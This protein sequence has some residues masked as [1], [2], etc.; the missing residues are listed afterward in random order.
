MQ[1]H[2]V[3]EAVEQ[4]DPKATV[5]DKV[6]K[7][8]LAKIYQSVPEETLLSLSEKKQAK[9]AW[10]AIRTVCQ[11]ADKAKAAKIQ[12]LKYEFESLSMKDTE[13]LDDFLLEARRTRFKY[14]SPW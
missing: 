6:D 7:V 8:A 5:E 10:E 14:S 9:D 1:A 3:W 2:G 12:T 11:G 13:L 4:T